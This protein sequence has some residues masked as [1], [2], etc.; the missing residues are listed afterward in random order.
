MG[1]LKTRGTQKSITLECIG[2]SRVHPEIVEVIT[3]ISGN[4]TL[5]APLFF[6]AKELIPVRKFTGN[7][8]KIA[9]KKLIDHCF[10]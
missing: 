2:V 9:E 1:Y 7:N 5:G 4:Q 6:G 8:S 10:T 3:G